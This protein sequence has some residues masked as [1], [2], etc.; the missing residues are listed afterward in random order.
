MLNP[1]KINY[2]CKHF[3]SVPKSF[4]IFNISFIQIWISLINEFLFRIT[5]NKD[6]CWKESKLSMSCISDNGFD[7]S[8][9]TLQVD[10]KLSVR[11]FLSCKQNGG[12]YY[13]LFFSLRIIR[14]VKPSGWML[15]LQEE[16]RF[17]NCLIFKFD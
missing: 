10:F 17:V 6:P 13:F 16:D 12:F 8:K 15:S 5:E 11:G 9:C 4:N 7:K 3:F 2:I 14:V 1:F